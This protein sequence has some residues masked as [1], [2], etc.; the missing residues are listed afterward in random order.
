MPKKTFVLARA[1]AAFGLVA[2]ISVLHAP[3]ASA[4]VARP[5]FKMPFP[6]GQV[7]FAR[8]YAGHPRF[9]VD[10]N[11]NGGGEAD[12]GQPVLAGAPGVAF[13]GRDSGYGNM[14]TVDHGNGW[15]SLYAHLSAVTVASGQAVAAD[16]PI[17][18][19]GR[20]GHSDGSHLHHEL[21]FNGVRQ[22][23]TLD[24]VAIFVSYNSR[25]ASYASTNCPPPPPPVRAKRWAW[26]WAC[27]FRCGPNYRVPLP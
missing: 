13:P 6:C 25:G 15:K 24:G 12:F 3:K 1:L 23:V 4:D 10:W 27:R 14:V 17:G 21:S 8:T 26:A 5:V 11:M 7:W 20:T 9:A 16:T 2:G 19:V 18:R 22:A